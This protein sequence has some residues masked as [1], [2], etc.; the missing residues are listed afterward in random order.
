MTT[1]VPA[2]IDWMTLRFTPAPCSSGTTR[3][4]RLLDVGLHRRHPTD[5]PDTRASPGRCR[6][7]TRSSQLPITVSGWRSSSAGS[8]S[9]STS[10][11]RY[12]TA[13]RF[14]RWRKFPTKYMP[15]A[16]LQRV[17]RALDLLGERQR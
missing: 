3:E 15:A 5:E 12:S 13:S 16:L 4:A 7:S 11:Q 6:A 14:G 10:A 9:G 1:G 8:S 2:I 17:R